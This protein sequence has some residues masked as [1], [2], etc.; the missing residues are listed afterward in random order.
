MPEPK[1]ALRLRLETEDLDDFCHD[2]QNMNLEGVNFSNAFLVANFRGANLKGSKFIEANV[3]TCN[4]SSTDLRQAN[5]SGAAIDAAVFAAANL[6][7]TNF[8]GASEQGHVYA[9][10]ELPWST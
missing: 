1:D 4:F 9:A 7:G 6:E 3:K 10:G 2:L 8:Q 5:F